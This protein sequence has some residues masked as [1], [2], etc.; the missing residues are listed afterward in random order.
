MA[1]ISIPGVKSRFDT[2]TLIEGLMKA[3]RIPKDRLEKNIETLEATRTTWQSLGRRISLVK[4]SA[5]ALYSF[6]N[7]FNDRTVVSS[8]NSVI[9]ASAS[10]DVREQSHSFVV[11]QTAQADKFIS[12]P[13]PADYNVPA[14]NYEFSNGKS[15]ISFTFPGGSLEDFSG[16][17]NAN[18]KDKITSSVIAVRSGTKSIIIESLVTGQENR[19]DF[20]GDA[21]KF[22]IDAGIVTKAISGPDVIKIP[23]VPY[24]GEAENFIPARAATNSL[25]VAPVTQTQ[26]ALKKG[27]EP[28]STMF[29]KFSAEVTDNTAAIKAADLADKNLVVAK[30]ALE[31]AKSENIQ[32]QNNVQSASAALE[33]AQKA[34]ENTQ[35]Q[36]TALNPAPN[37]PP[38]AAAG[39]EAAQAEQAESAP[40][41]AQ[42]EQAEGAQQTAQ[43]EQAEGAPQTAQARQTE[44]AQQ[45]AHDEQAGGAP[46][47]AQV[48]QAVGAPQTAQAAEKAEGAQQTA[49]VEQAEG[50][51]Q[52]AQAERAEGAQQT[53]QAERAEGAPEGQQEQVQQAEDR[54]ALAAQLQ[55][56]LQTQESGLTLA[57]NALKDAQ[58]KQTQAGAKQDSAELALANAENQIVPRVENQN[59][60]KVYFEDGTFKELDPLEGGFDKEYNLNLFDL[61]G[62]KKA[63]FIG[64]DNQNTLRDVTIHD[65]EVVETAPKRESRPVQPISVASDAILSMDGIEVQRPANEIDDL[66]PGMTLKVRS[67][68]ESPVSLDVQDDTEA[69]KNAMISFVGNY[70]RLMVELNVVTRNDET[71][72]DE[73]SYLDQ[74]E[75]DDLKSRLGALSG[76]PFVTKLRTDLVNIMNAPYETN[77]GPAMLAGFGISTDVRRSGIAGYDPSRTRGYLEIDENA[78]DDALAVKEDTLRQLMGRDSNGDMIVDSGLAY[79]V[80]RATRPFVETGGIISN[81][82]NGINT[83]ISSDKRR[84]ETIDRQLSQKEATLRRQ[85]GQMEDAYNRM[86]RMSNSLDSFNQSGKK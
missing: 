85:Y 53:A 9:E 14:G 49:Q 5:D 65:I 1:D 84:I 27:I 55:E 56:Q 43:A 52:T 57:E 60:F 24:K 46:Q 29:L 36:I 67:A 68:S 50:A 58:M 66:I 31:A 59:V 25:R 19:L 26:I 18:A 75:R 4:D 11:K 30:N 83:Q 62:G 80:D 23:A 63:V 72:I 28:T 21:L 71:L 70:N 78:L 69:V 8:N 45:T 6:Q 32:A 38:E 47:T 2:E 15:T 51:Q 41:T 77:S 12:K 3:Q 10:R 76:D 54:Q 35:N 79:S 42:P 64:I 34:V 48:E 16:A 7:P 81:K 61:G 17:L 33:N 40:Q 13:L 74:A 82:T 39:Q 86:E 44:G 37:T 22:G 20:S 73:V